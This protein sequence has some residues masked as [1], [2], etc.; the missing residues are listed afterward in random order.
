MA[1]NVHIY[2]TI[3][4]NKFA[5]YIEFCSGIPGHADG[6]KCSYLL[7]YYNQW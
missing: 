2:I 3:N 5:I 7:V 1:Q 4:S 6:S